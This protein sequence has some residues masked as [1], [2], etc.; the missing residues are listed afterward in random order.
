MPFSTGQLTHNLEVGVA[1]VSNKKEKLS[2][3]HK[4]GY[5]SS[6]GTAY[7]TIWDGGGVYTFP[8]SATTATVTSASGATDSGVQV[9]IEGLDAN[10]VVQS[11]TVTLNASGTFTTTNTYLRLHRAYVAGSTAASGDITITVDSLTVAK[12]LSA[13]QQT[14]MLVYTVPAGH[15]AYLLQV[16]A[17]VQK[18]KEIV[19][20]IMTREEN[21][22]FLTKG[23]LASFATPVARKFDIPMMLPEK[24]DIRID[25]K[26]GATTEITGEF[27][28]VL[29]A[30]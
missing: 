19:A 29:E 3:I 12:I 11:E 1:I 2:G 20:K 10:Y 15:T 25:A 23:I 6:V 30:N 26:A 13:Y 27:E 22:V 17:G 24:T 16:D 9:Y 18:E 7:E 14:E 4:F 21:G 28:I 8:S 5:N